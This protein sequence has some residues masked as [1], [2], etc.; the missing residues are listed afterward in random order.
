MVATSPLLGGAPTRRT[1][2]AVVA[3]ALVGALGL[4]LLAM[5]TQSRGA[6]PLALA[7]MNSYTSWLGGLGEED[8]TSEFQNDV[9]SPLPLQIPW[10]INLI[11]CSGRSC[12][13][14]AV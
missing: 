1:G 12:S 3:A 6:Q 13:L 10:D 9:V 5:S 7:E 11:A 14:R 4:A 8:E 2:R